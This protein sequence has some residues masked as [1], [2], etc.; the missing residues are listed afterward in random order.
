MAKREKGSSPS[1]RLGAGMAQARGGFRACVRRCGPKESAMTWLAS[2][3]TCGPGRMWPGSSWSPG[4]LWRGAV[5]EVAAVVPPMAIPAAAGPAGPGA[6]GARSGAEAWRAGT[7]PL[8]RRAC[9]AEEYRCRCPFDGCR[10]EPVR[11]A[12]GSRQ[13]RWHGDRARFGAGGGSPLAGL[14]H[15]LEDGGSSS[16]MVRIRTLT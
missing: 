15:R 2:A 14:A 6:P 16:N 12:A 7:G 1:A 10:P 3:R 11:C 9:A 8:P 4:D 13:F 5:G